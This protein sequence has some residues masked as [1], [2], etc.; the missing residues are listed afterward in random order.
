MKKLLVDI[1]NEVRD[2]SPILRETC[3]GAKSLFRHLAFVQTLSGRENR[4]ALVFDVPEIPKLII[5]LLNK[6]LNAK[7]VVS[8]LNKDLY[9][10]VYVR[11][12]TASYLAV[13]KWHNRYR[14]P[15]KSFTRSTTYD[16]YLTVSKPT[17]NY[18]SWSVRHGDAFRAYFAA[19]SPCRYV[20]VYPCAPENVLNVS[21][22]ISG[23]TTYG[24][25][26]V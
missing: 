19:T 10:P 16:Y 25:F 13:K 6:T 20:D 9:A 15:R 26:T 21:E 2:V 3:L 14:V 23:L 22:F 1:A 12:A 24:E 18:I 4:V 7:Q 17:P 8:H 5:V 11:V